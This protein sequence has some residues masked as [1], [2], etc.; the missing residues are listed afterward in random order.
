MILGIIGNGAIGQYVQ[1]HA[2][3]MGHTVDIVLTRNNSVSDIHDRVEHVIDC[4]GHE[5][6]QTF[7]PG[8]LQRGTDLTTVSL[9][10]L[11]D[12]SVRLALE[13]AA[14]AGDAKLHLAS[15]AIGSLDCLLAARVG[16]LDSV[17]YVGRKPPAGW[18]GSPADEVLDLD[19]LRQ[20]AEKHFDG[21]ARDA[22][23]RY[24]KNANVA[25]AVAL[26]GLGFER[27]RVKLI[28]DADI[29][30]NIHEVEAIGAFGRFSFTIAGRPLPDN[31]RSSAL[32]AMSVIAKLEQQTSRMVI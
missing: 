25:A 1:Y 29:T 10:A 28:A 18:R 23:Q 30:E 15:G 27:T 19:Q 20:G 5:A 13:S 3:E 8:I 7:G 21:N 22:A 26:A 17:T 9:G 2:A 12:D 6:L 14:E 31:P 32:A 11:A 24:P 16:G 4:A